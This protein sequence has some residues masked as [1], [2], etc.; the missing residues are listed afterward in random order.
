MFK[1][2]SLCIVFAATMPLWSQVEPSATGGGF[3]LDDE[4]MMT[5]P[6]VS[7]D[8]Y[9]VIVGAETRSNY[10]SGGLVFTGAYTDNLLR[11]NGNDPVSDE[12]YTFLP[13]IALDRRTPRQ[14][15]SLRYSTGFSVYQHTSEL[16]GITQDGSAGYRFHISP[17][18]MVVI[19]DSFQQNYNLYNQSNPFGAGGVSGAPGSSNTALIQPFA[20]QLQNTTSAGIEYQYGKNAMVGASG[21]YSFLQYG[22]LTTDAQGLS[23]EDTAGANAFFS[24][25]IGRAEYVGVTYQLSKFVT[26]P[27]GTYTL[28][29]VAFGF[30]THYFTRSFSFSVLGG[31][32]HYTSWSQVNPK[33][34]AWTPAVQG[35]LGW[36]APRANLAASFSHVVSGAG[37]L[38]G[39]FH[40][41]IGSLDGRYT[42]S[43]TWSLNA[44]ASYMLFKNINPSTVQFASYAGGHTIS[45]GANVQHRIANWM[46]ANAGYEHIHQSYANITVSN[47][48]F[49]SNRAY[50]S[51]TCEFN[52]PLGR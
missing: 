17:Y 22:N 44:N 47:S 41:D 15:E 18:A 6:P 8:A 40:S 11:F 42:F 13:T 2:A 37:G 25:R 12:T 52:R 5:P 48:Q 49:D 43:R 39:T 4:H 31:P 20:N 29:N 3:T 9:P 10:I 50:V 33:A 32:E 38:I 7:R 46:Y 45:G 51:I 28:S 14:G 21:T 24:R 34:G 1:F 19:N 30:Y 35:S 23:N 26:H 36:Q 16:N 27:I